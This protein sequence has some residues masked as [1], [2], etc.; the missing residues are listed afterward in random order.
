MLLPLYWGKSRHSRITGFPVGAYHTRNGNSELIEAAKRIFD[1]A[2]RSVSAP[3][4]MESAGDLLIS[5]P[6]RVVGAGK[7]AM[8][9]AASL[10]QQFPECS[11]EGQV[12]V[13]HG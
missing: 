12:V 9:M 6:C 4:F 10:E 1:A 2:V 5:G 11:F 3:Q 7:A 13:P 8:A